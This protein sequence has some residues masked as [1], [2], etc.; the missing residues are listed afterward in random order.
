MKM[1]EIERRLLL[2]SAA[3]A[4]A[5]GLI[6][7]KARAQTAGDPAHLT[8]PDRMARLIAGAKKEGVL[9]LYSSAIAEHMNA[10]GAAFEKKYG[11]KFVLWRGG[12]E[13]ILQRI[14]T[15]ARGGHFAVDVAET[16]A[17]QI[18]AL[19]R[20][21]LLQ[22]VDTP[23]RG[24]IM[25][26]TIIPGAPWLPSRLVVFTGAYNTNLIK[27]ADL[28]KRYEDLLDPKWKGKLAIE[29]DDNNWLMA[30]SGTL[31]EE[32]GIKLFRDI[33]A[34]NGVSVRKGHTLMANLVAS[35]EVPIALTV[36]HHEVAPLKRAGA[37]IDE[38]DI[39]PVFAFAAGTGMA[40]RAPHPY[41][42]VLFIDFLLSDGQKILAEHDNV[43]TN[44]KYPTLPKEVKIFF[45]DVPKYMDESAKWTKLYK[46]IL[47][48]QKR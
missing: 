32:K 9:N 29:A 26:G 10:V 22:A 20:E 42:A 8:G 3:A 40:R 28:P 5:L 6:P 39:A 11:V 43:P 21:K 19:D 15:E 16:A 4:A 33:V 18:V 2:R 7:W 27:K 47:L 45:L 13:E 12:S 23:L 1:F 36:Y 24:E 44:V 25:P 30:L 46:D 38:L 34:K 41:A 17:P 14:V 37:P 35:G 48:N 31:G